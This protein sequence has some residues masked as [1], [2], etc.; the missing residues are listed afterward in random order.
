MLDTEICPFLNSP[1]DNDS[2][3]DKNKTGMNISLDTVC[4]GKVESKLFK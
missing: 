1:I 3:M 4:L 2:E